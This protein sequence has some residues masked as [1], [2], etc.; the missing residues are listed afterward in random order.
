MLRE[1]HILSA[2]LIAMTML[3]IGCG[4]D[5][6]KQQLSDE[7]PY[8]GL[9]AE[10]RTDSI[11]EVLVEFDNVSYSTLATKTIRL[12][13][14]TDRPITLLEHKSTCRCTW[15]ELPTKAIDAGDYADI[16]LIFDSRGEFG[17]VGNYVDI[18]TSDPRCRIGIWMSAQVTR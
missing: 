2:A 1:G 9:E 18:T 4:N 13:N 14:P 8:Q 16:E 17:S 12:S 15:V 10:I 5:T 6:T 3:S 7:L 11:T